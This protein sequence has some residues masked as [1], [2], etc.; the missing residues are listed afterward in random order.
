MVEAAA[1]DAKALAET[2][3]MVTEMVEVAALA[4]EVEVGEVAMEVDVVA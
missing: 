1:K 3:E 2:A 4:E